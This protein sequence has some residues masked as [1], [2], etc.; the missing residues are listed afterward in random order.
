[1]LLNVLKHLSKRFF[2]SATPKENKYLVGKKLFENGELRSAIVAFREHLTDHP[3]DVA[4]LNDLGCSLDSIG[5]TKS[6]GECFKKAITI[7]EAYPP[8]VINHAKYLVENRQIDEAYPLLRRLKAI[9]PDSPHLYSLL[10]SIAHR[11]GNAAEGSRQDLKAWLQS[12]DNLRLANCYLF[13]LSYSE[14]DEKKVAIEHK[15][16]ADT[17]KKRTSPEHLPEESPVASQKKNTSKIRIGYWSPDFRNHSVRYFIRPL[18]ENHDK[19]AFEVYIYHDFPIKDE[20]TAAIEKT[21]DCFSNVFDLPDQEVCKLITSHDLDILVE[22]SGHTSANRINLLQ[23]RLAKIQITGLGYPPTTGLKTIDAKIVDQH[24]ITDESSELFTEFPVVLNSSFWSFDPSDEIPLPEAPPFEKNGYISFGCI[25]NISKI[26]PDALAAW[27]A[28]LSAVPESKLIIRSISF[29][30]EAGIRNFSK[31]LAEAKI[32]LE[33]TSL[34]GPTQTRE[35]FI[36]YNEVDVILDTYPFNGGT[37][38][39]F[40]AYMGVPTITL[41]GKSLSSRMGLSIMKNLQ[42]EECIATT[43]EEY[44]ALAT[45]VA[46]RPEFIT[47]TRKE[48]RDRFKSSALGN[49]Q[50]FT[51]EFEEKCLELVTQPPQNTHKNNV[52]PLPLTETIERAYAVLKNGQFD[53]A[54]R[55][56]DYCLKH[57]P[58]SGSAHVLKTYEFTS[59]QNFIEA[60][61]YLIEQL[62]KIQEADAANVLINIARFFIT[63]KQYENA[64]QY[65]ELAKTKRAANI[66]QENQIR[67]LDAYFRAEKETPAGSKETSNQ[68]AINIV[69]VSRNADDFRAKKQTLEKLHPPSKT[70]KVNYIECQ[71]NWRKMTYIQSITAPA[72]DATIIINSDATPCHPNFFHEILES[73]E[74]ADILSFA[75]SRQW[76]QIDWEKS[77]FDDKTISVIHPSGE[78]DGLFELVLC[79]NTQHKI[80]HGMTV[81][82]GKL[83]AIKNSAIPATQIDALFDSELEGGGTLLEQYFSHLANRKHGTRL[84][85]HANLGILVDWSKETPPLAREGRWIMS[86]KLGFDPLVE[87]DEDTSSISLN[88]ESPQH[89]V[90]IVEKFLE[91]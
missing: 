19:E 77:P 8:L 21:A 68:S 47:R 82:S 40:S 76:T 59:G 42:L 6:A 17:L 88:I 52:H 61:H 35:L 72:I 4:A 86:E 62:G 58:Y 83:L 12:F 14:I 3:L 54:E 7:D 63:A 32:P 80:S 50:L 11:I 90:S 84:A 81:L 89:G 75:G 57:Y 1:M 85:A 51:K 48:L 36:S 30:D 64:K 71:E 16:W 9:E 60:A 20:Q 49:G 22:L 78:A 56:V 44:I 5:D 55:I 45:A 37:T 27:N 70:T 13:H 41:A 25:G 73:L 38:T 53:A 26:T 24:I 66:N 79:G 18:L 74:E 15:F 91:K 46:R 39:C 29:N 87:V 69:L 43:W 28:I 2:K 33:R 67:L 23:D 65:A 34:L 10:G 31:K